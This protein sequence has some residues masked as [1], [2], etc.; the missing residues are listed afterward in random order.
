MVM[1]GYVNYFYKGGQLPAHTRDSLKDYE[2][3]TIHD[4][5]VKNAY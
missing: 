3:L 4:I 5:I 1:P 2:I